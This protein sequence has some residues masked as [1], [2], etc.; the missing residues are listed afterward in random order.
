MA[1]L[2]LCRH[3]ASWP[4]C[5]TIKCASGSVGEAGPRAQEDPAV[6]VLPGKSRV[7]DTQGRPQKAWGVNEYPVSSCAMQSGVILLRPSAVRVSTCFF[8]RFWQGRMT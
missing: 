7:A 5:N 2:E 1:T 6:T 3:L 8:R 4:A